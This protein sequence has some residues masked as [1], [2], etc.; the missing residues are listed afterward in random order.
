MNGPARRRADSRRI[1][2]DG[3]AFHV[4]LSA[5]GP[6]S[7]AEDRLPV[8]LLHGFTGSVATW[9][10]CTTSLTA[11]GHPVIAVDLIGHGAS[12]APGGAGRYAMERAADDLVAV[13]EAL[14]HE[15][16]RWIGYSL[17]GRAALVVAVRHPERVAALVLEGAT[18]GIADAAERAARVRADG[19]LADRIERE[20]IPAF[21]DAWEG[22]PL[23]D[24]QGS[25][26]AEVRAR[27]RRQRLANR[28]T[29]LAHSLR[30]MGAGAQP[31]LWERLGTLPVPTLL[32]AGA[33]DEKFTAIGRE[34]AHALPDARMEPIEGAGHAAHLERPQPFAE[35]VIRFLDGAGGREQ[36]RRD[37]A[38]EAR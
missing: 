37:G 3:V 22:L 20:G 6:G 16:A 28:A 4:E 18:A 1:V 7:P 9:D 25:L 15:R 36:A 12:D 35:A 32:L 8:V 13:L 23:W 17:G 27:L 14:G 29:G 33:L 24:S 19:V 21:V 34:M 38:T 5:A 11:A 26:P 31:S 2:V 30:G 10:A